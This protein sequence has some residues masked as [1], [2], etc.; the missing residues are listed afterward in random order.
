M[1]KYL[2]LAGVKALWKV[3]SDKYNPAL[4]ASGT[5]INAITGVTGTNVQAALG[6]IYDQLKTVEGKADSWK[7]K[8]LSSAEVIK[9]TYTPGAEGAQGTYNP[10][11]D[12]QVLHLVVKAEGETDATDVYVDVS[13]LIDKYDGSNVVLTGY[14]KGTSDA[15]ISPEDKLNQALSK[16]AVGIDNAKKK[17]AEAEGKIPT[18]V[19]LS[20]S[21]NSVSATLGSTGSVKIAAGTNMGSVATANGTIT[22]SGKDWSTE[23][24]DAKAAGTSVAVGLQGTLATGK[25]TVSTKGTGAGSGSVAITAGNNIT[26]TTAADGVTVA[27]KDWTSDINNAITNAAG[28][29]ATAAQ[30]GKADTALQEVTVNGSKLT[31]ANSSVTLNGGN[32]LTAAAIGGSG[33]APTYAASTAIDT[34]LAGLDS[35]ISSLKTS[36]DSKLSGV[37]LNG[38]VI[39]PTDGVVNLAVDGASLYVDNAAQTKQTIKAAIE[40]AASDASKGISDAATAQAKADANAAS[41]TTLQNSLGNYQEKLSELSAAGTEFSLVKY[42]KLGVVTEGRKLQEADIT[43]LGFQT[44]K[45]E[46]GA[47]ADEAIP[48]EEITEANLSTK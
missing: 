9:G 21:E 23:I 7:D 45:F 31:Q 34:V 47:T 35:R 42:S 41:I 40:S 22:I 19:G 6:S 30:G 4:T 25:Y 18:T 28:N 24:A 46:N 14:T 36:S 12:G 37:K 43:A 20:A 17:A 13:K 15:D 27:G 1:A 39:T 16:L 29:Y 10:D 32:V 33:S 2:D 44:G 38:T 11:G 3:I 26:L 8:F 5:S 48:V